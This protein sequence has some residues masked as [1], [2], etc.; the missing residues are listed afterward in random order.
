MESNTFK[1]ANIYKIFNDEYLK[2]AYFSTFINVPY[3]NLNYVCK[4]HY[5]IESKDFGIIC[6]HNFHDY[7]IIDEKKWFLNRLKYGI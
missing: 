5:F 7:K 4:W 2:I 6:I 1:N 3:Q